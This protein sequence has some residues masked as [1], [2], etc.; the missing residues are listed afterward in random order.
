MTEPDGG[1]PYWPSAWPGHYKP[2]PLGKVSAKQ[3]DEVKMGNIKYRGDLKAKAQKL[4]VNMTKEERHL[5]YDFLKGYGVNF[6]RQ[7]PIGNYI[8]DFYCARARLVIE[9]DGGRHY[10]PDEMEYDKRRTDYFNAIGISVLRFS[11]MDIWHNFN[12]VCI[13]ID[14]FVK[15]RGV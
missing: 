6:Y 5:W 15:N 9:I 2:S 10:E 7:K 11:N 8:A 12:G 13:K 4:R 1:I 3:T 14:D